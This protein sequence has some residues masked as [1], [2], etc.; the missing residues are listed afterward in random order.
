MYI[1]VHVHVCVCVCVYS[2]KMCVYAYFM[3]ELWKHNTSAVFMCV[4]VHVFIGHYGCGPESS[5]DII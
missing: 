5:A 3:R 2:R 1:C 4:C